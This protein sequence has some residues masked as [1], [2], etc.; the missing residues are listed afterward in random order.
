MKNYI[1]LITIILLLLITVGCNPPQKVDTPVQN[2]REYVSP[3]FIVAGVPIVKG[4]LNH[5]E[6]Y[7][8]VDTGATFSLLDVTQS[9]DYGF[10]VIGPDQSVTA[11][12]LGG[13]YTNLDSLSEY[14]VH[15]NELSVNNFKGTD[16]A[17]L[18]S[19][20]SSISGKHVVGIVGSNHLIEEG[21]IIDYSDNAI[22]K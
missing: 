18:M 1:N 3:M 14:D 13:S 22:Y 8:M 7:F 15:I 11:Y 20:L 10:K 5:K 4:E 9:E 16:L 6:A 12:G 2:K 19:V 17:H 21:L